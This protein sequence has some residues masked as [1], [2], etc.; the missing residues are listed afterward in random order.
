[1]KQQIKIL[2]STIKKEK[3]FLKETKDSKHSPVYRRRGVEGFSPLFSFYFVH[4]N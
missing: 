3:T 4:L 2:S 1:M